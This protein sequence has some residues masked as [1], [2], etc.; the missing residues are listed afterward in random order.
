MIMDRATR[1]R[2]IR[3]R[4]KFTCDCVACVENYPMTKTYKFVQTYR[5]INPLDHNQLCDDYKVDDIKR[6][7]PKYCKFLTANSKKYPNNHTNTAEEML[8]EM[9]RLAYT[10]A[11]PLAEKIRLQL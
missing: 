7:I 10:E 3:N 4:L 6:L 2:E 11:V 8:Y 5:F 9:F 1:Q